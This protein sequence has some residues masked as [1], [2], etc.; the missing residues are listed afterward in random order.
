MNVARIAG[1]LAI[2]T[3]L[4]APLGCSNRKTPLPGR[5]CYLNSDCEDPLSCTFNKC[6]EAC[7]ESGD[8]PNGGLCIYAPAAPASRD[9]QMSMPDAGLLKVCVQES[10]AMN[11]DCPDL[12]VCGRDLRC[13]QEC[14]ASKDCPSRNQ[15]CVIGNDQGQKVCAEAIDIGDNGQLLLADGGLPP[16]NDAGAPDVNSGP[17]GATGG[18]GQAGGGGGHGDGDANA[19]DAAASDAPIDQT[20]SGVKDASTDTPASNEAGAQDTPA[21]VSTTV[22]DAAVDGGPIAVAEQEPNDEIN[23]PTPYVLGTEVAGTMGKADGSMDINDYYEVVAPPG[24]PSGGYF[25]ASIA[26][27]PGGGAVFGAV[28]SAFD[29]GMLLLADG[30]DPGQSTFFF[31]AG[32]PGQHYLVRLYEGGVVVPTF[33]YTFKVTYTRIADEL[34]PND[35]SDTPAPLALGAPTTAYFFAGYNSSLPTADQ[36]WYSVMLGA[37]TTHVTIDPVPHDVRMQFLVYDS[38]FQQVTTTGSPGM[39]LGASILNGA[40]TISQPGIYRI[41]VQ[42]FSFVAGS[43]ANRGVV[44]PDSFTRPYTIT[45]TQP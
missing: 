10:C 33:Q 34:E 30:A 18:G 14:A 3:L 23:A 32:K 12:L 16:A 22:P 35:T 4:A 31:W 36:D 25:Q 42:A 8:C 24:D 41:A 38:H 29:N 44:L 27:K 11:S 37:G 39:N 6:H 40:F 9:A 2:A 13:R 21:D 28:F 17:G 19:P 43:V 26:S 15:L 5:S 1:A 45:V 7:R 20:G